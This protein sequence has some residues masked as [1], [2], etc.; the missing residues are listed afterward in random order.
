LDE[1][2]ANT[3]LFVVSPKFVYDFRPPKDPTRISP[4][5]KADMQFNAA[6]PYPEGGALVVGPKG[7]I[8]SI[9]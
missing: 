9:P 2:Q 1:N 7:T 8:A 3:R 4:R 6:S 5:K